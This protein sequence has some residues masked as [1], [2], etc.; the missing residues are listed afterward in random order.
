MEH[1]PRKRLV[2]SFTYMPPE[3]SAVP[4]STLLRINNEYR[5]HSTA[6][7]IRTIAAELKLDLKRWDAEMEALGYLNEC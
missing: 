2:A 4:T 7:I 1:S 3:P 6:D 5:R